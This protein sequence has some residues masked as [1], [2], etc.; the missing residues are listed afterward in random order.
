LKLHEKVGEDYYRDVLGKMRG[1]ERDT[2][3]VQFG[4]TGNGHSPNYQ[5]TR[6]DGGIECYAGLNHQF[7]T[8]TDIYTDK[9]LSEPYTYSEIQILL[10]RSMEMGWK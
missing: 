4:L 3:I 7:D 5:V 1:R 8:R 10:Q 9:N 2:V 6:A